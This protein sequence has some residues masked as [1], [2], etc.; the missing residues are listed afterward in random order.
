[1]RMDLA[2]CTQCPRLRFSSTLRVEAISGGQRLDK[3]YSPRE[4]VPR[5]MHTETVPASLDDVAAWAKDIIF[6]GLFIKL[7]TCNKCSLFACRSNY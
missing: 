6:R 7:Y 5:E 3:H 4:Q 2:Q 1:V